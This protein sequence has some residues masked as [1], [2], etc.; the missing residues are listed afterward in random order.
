MCVIIRTLTCDPDSPV[1]VFKDLRGQPFLVLLIQDQSVVD[2]MGKA[3]THSNPKASISGP[4]QCQDRGGGQLFTR[5]SNPWNKSYAIKFEES[6]ISSHPNVAI[7][8]LC[9]GVGHPPKISVLHS[10]DPM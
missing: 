10:P 1:F 9:D 7:C 8:S 3:G 5:L 2:E 4:Q 6:G